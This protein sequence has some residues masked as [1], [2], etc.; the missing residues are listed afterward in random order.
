MISSNFKKGSVSCLGTIVLS[1]ITWGRLTD[2]VQTVN[3][4][5]PATWIVFMIM[6]CLFMLLIKFHTTTFE[7][8][9]E[10][11]SYLLLKDRMW[12]RHFATN[13]NQKAFPSSV[14]WNVVSFILKQPE[15]KESD[16]TSKIIILTLG[17]LVLLIV[18]SVFENTIKAEKM[19]TYIPS[20]S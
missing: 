3:G 16:F 11:H 5:S 15:L 17:L 7:L 9:Q 8:C 14:S 10:I 12:S 19:T 6:L 4:F 13:L 1:K 20:V 18:K 2:F